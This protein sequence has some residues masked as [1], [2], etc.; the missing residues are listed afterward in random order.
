MTYLTRHIGRALLRLSL[1]ALLALA[2]LGAAHAGST[3]GAPRAQAAQDDFHM[4]LP[5]ISGAASV[6]PTPDLRFDPAG[7]VRAPGGGGSTSVRVQPSTDLSTAT[8]WLEGTGD[9]LNVRFQSAADGKSGTLTLTASDTAAVGAQ[10]LTVKGRNGDGTKTWVG[11]LQFTVASTRART[12]FVDPVNGSDTNKGTQTKPFQT[13]AKALS[14]AQAGDTIRLAAGLYTDLPRT[15]GSAERFSSARESTPSVIVPAGVTIIGDSNDVI[16][17]AGFELD[18][19]LVFAGAATVRN[20]TLKGFAVGMRATQ[21]QQSLSE[22]QLANNL[23]GLV[24]SGTAQALL[25]NSMIAMNNDSFNGVLASQQAGFTMDGGRIAGVQGN[26]ATRADGIALRDAARAALN[27]NAVLEDIPGNALDMRDTAQASLTSTTITR[28]NLSDCAPAP[29]VFIANSA[30]LTTI[31]ES[32]TPTTFSMSGGRSTV[33]IFVE[34]DA[35]Q[36]IK[37]SVI[38][39]HTNA[40]ILGGAHLRLAL[41]KSL[42]SQNGTGIDA[43]STP[44]PSLDIIGAVLIA[45]DSVGTPTSKVKRHH[46]SVR[47]NRFGIVI[48]KA[49]SSTQID[50]GTL[51]ED[52][53]NHIFGQSATGVTFDP[54]ITQFSG[55]TVV[56]AVGNFWNPNVQGTDGFGLYPFHQKVSGLDGIARGP[57]FNM[58]NGQTAIQL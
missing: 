44:N 48:T 42:I 8:F 28:R 33:G 19:G 20:V 41:S 34:S 2:S 36:T 1:L 57:N 54:T 15:D 11:S 23:N 21:G 24:L 37:N 56:N 55:A 47:N 22:L 9:G 50:L 45:P 18:I 52:G 25:G 26:C 51:A 4:F 14:K 27:N 53:S 39:G 46:A 32:E 40:G 49:D 58:P 38:T 16:L 5:T 29:S 13:L 3:A 43:G 6:A 31:E 7:W 10:T 17:Q 30:A 35:T 12:F